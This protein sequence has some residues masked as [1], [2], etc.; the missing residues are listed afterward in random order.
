MFYK[1]FSVTAVANDTTLDSGLVSEVGKPVHVRAVII[2]VSVHVGNVLECWIGTKRV[3]ELYDYSIDTQEL[4]AGNDQLSGTKIV[5]LEIDLDVQPGQVFKIGLNCGAT[6]ATLT[7]A[8][9]YTE[10]T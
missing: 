5:R 4:S 7:G 2:N 3:T 1:G 10:P 8:Y 6:G 9:E